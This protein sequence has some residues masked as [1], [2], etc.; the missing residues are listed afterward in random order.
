MSSLNLEFEW[1]TP[2]GIRG[3][4]LRATWASLE[5]RLADAPVT[6]IDH[7][8][9]SVRSNLFLPLYPLAEWIATHWWFLFYEVETPG[10]STS[11]RY[12]K[13]HN[14]RYGAEGYAVPSLTIQ[15]LGEQIKLEWSRSFLHAQRIEFIVSG[16]S[17][18]SSSELQYTLS[19]FVSAAIK[20]LHEYGIEGSLLEQEWSSIQGVDSEESEFCATAAAL[21]LDPY[22]LNDPEQQE[23]LTVSEQMPPSLL[24]DFFAVA[25]LD[26]LRN[27]AQQVL[28]ALDASRENRANLES[29]KSLRNELD[30]VRL[31]SQGSPWVQGYRFAHE[32]R[33]KLH[34]N[35]ERLNSF[36]DL[37]R[38]L[39]ISPRELKKAII[40]VPSLPE[41][42]DALV[43]TN[44]VESPGFAVP[45]RREEAIRFA[46]CRALFEYLKTPIGQPL[47]VTRSRSDRQKRNRA[48]AA[49]FLVPADLLRE[50]IP[51]HRLSYEELDDLAANF[52]VSSSIIRHQIENHGLATS[53]PV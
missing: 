42:L 23:I 30:G 39:D 17:F 53:L 27:Q 28:K 21:G 16:T 34:L 38:T 13:R 46:F 20:R 50:A 6:F 14:I 52:G 29:I 41:T 48:F 8:S 12:D 33:R 10:R 1:L 15:P 18:V 31:L 26:A 35:G 3:P 49:E 22:S 32:V 4:E 47:L 51:G 43:A 5:I 44:S 11:D 2:E 37:G 19:A 40:E 36:Q 7:S 9:R 25:D 45:K 24:R